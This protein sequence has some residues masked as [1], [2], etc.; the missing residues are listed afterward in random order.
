VAFVMLLG[1]PVPAGNATPAEISEPIGLAAPAITAASPEISAQVE[2]VVGSEVDHDYYPEYPWGSASASGILTV[3]LGGF[4]PPATW[5]VTDWYAGMAPEERAAGSIG[6]YGVDMSITIQTGF[7]DY[8]DDFGGGSFK[9]THWAIDA[10]NGAGDATTVNVSSPMVVVQEDGTNA[11][12]DA[13]EPGVT[14]ATRGNWRTS[15][16]DGWLGG[17]T[18]WT[19]RRWSRM[20]FT[21][22][23]SEG[24]VI[25]VVM[26]MAEN[27]GEARIKLDGVKAADVDTYVEGPRQHRIVM[28]QTGPLAAGEHTIEVINLA[29]D[30]HP[31]IDVDAFMIA[32]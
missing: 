5:A 18:A 23:V 25:A 19:N 21:A 2:F 4:E 29:T 8:D 31:R 12:F 30:G 11:R 16:W 28:W 24:Q 15:N 9:H 13:P 6:A 27:R 17:H 1:W 10:E 20:T 22:T 14:V 32:G 26:P 7:T 3:D